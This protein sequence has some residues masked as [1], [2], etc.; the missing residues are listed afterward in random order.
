MLS[1]IDKEWNEGKKAFGSKC[2]DPIT[3]YCDNN[4][5]NNDFENRLV[6]FF[7]NWSKSQDSF[8][9]LHGE[10]PDDMERMFDLK[11][12]SGTLISLN[13]PALNNG[14][15]K[16]S[17]IVLAEDLNNMHAQR[18]V[19]KPKLSAR[20]QS[21]KVGDGNLSSPSFRACHLAKN[22]EFHFNFT[23]LHSFIEC[24]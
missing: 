18:R 6:D 1:Y 11:S 4:K 19:Q 8:H 14:Y 24:R 9:F 21:R 5:D 16:T 3:V 20:R 2:L 22:F 13:P 17:V 10:F 12:E 23:F 15:M 7:F